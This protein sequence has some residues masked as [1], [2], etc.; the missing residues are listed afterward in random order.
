MGSK[1]W[2][3]WTYIQ[4]KNRLRDIDNELVVAGEMGVG[5]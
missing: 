1:I 3:K 2:L 5:M 4:N